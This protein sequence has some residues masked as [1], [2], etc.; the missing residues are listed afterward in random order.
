MEKDSNNLIIISMVLNIVFV[1]ITTVYTGD[2]VVG[3]IEDL[4]VSTADTR[5]MIND[6]RN[7]DNVLIAS[8]G[9]ILSYVEGIVNIFTFLYFLLRFFLGNLLIAPLNL[10]ATGTTVIE[11][12]GS[13]FVSLFVI[14][15]N[16]VLIKAAY[17]RLV[18][19]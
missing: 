7:S 5:S 16:G 12:I 1:L 18:K 11:R 3:L 17:E 15:N 10:V 9:T 19:G 4:E 14:I 13:A 6:F 8:A 2:S